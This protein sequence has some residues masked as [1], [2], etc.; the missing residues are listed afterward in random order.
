MALLHRRKNL[1]LGLIWNMRIVSNG[2]HR[3]LKCG[4]VGDCVNARLVAVAPGEDRDGRRRRR[5]SQ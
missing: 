5:Q 1:S 3:L 2:V 4:R